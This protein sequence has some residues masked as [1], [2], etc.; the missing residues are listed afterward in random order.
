MWLTEDTGEIFREKLEKGRTG[1][2]TEKDSGNRKHRAKAR[3]WHTESGALM[4]RV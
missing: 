2:F 1:H 4:K 3:E